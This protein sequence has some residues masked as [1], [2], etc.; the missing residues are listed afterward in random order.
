MRYFHKQFEVIQWFE[1]L[2]TS[3]TK[4]KII[5]AAKTMDAPTGK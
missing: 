5:E 4:E 2:P 3:V 1:W